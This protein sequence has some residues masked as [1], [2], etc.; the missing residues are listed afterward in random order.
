MPFNPPKTFGQPDVLKTITPAI[1]IKI[2]KPCH[3]FL[4]AA[5]LSLPESAEMEIDYLLLASVLATPDERMDSYVV[6]GLHVITT[7]GTDENFDE[8]LDMARRN[9]IEVDLEAT[10]CDLAARIWLA[11]PQTLQLKD[12]EQMVGRRRKFESFRARDPEIVVPLE[13]LPTDLRPLQEDLEAGF[14]SKKYGIGCVVVRTDIGREA[15]LLIQHGE[16]CKRV[17]SRKGA[18]STC[19]LYRPEQTDKAIIDL[20]HNELRMNASGPWKL[21]LYR[22]KIGLHLF[23]DPDK[24]VYAEKYTLAPLQKYGPAALY[25]RDVGGIERVRLVDLEYVSDH[26]LNFIERLRADDVFQAL[27]LKNR[28]IESDVEIRR[29]AFEVKLQGERRLRPVEIQPRNIAKYGRGEE[30]PIIEQWLH[31]REFVLV[32]TAAED[33]RFESVLALA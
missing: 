32:G 18:E 20:V 31:L 9:F 4:E 22:E 17:P 23:G 14:Q 26:S 15:H 19:T 5:G 27:A 25:C 30:A 7:V 11:A 6:E 24:F 2:L 13:K 28:S 10:A 8:L 16:P 33:E 3:A 21:R 29:A 12:R 1:L